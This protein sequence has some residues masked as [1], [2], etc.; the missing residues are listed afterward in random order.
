MWE[1]WLVA[2]MEPAWT[3]LETCSDHTVWA[4]LCY[5][6]C[7]GRIMDAFRFIPSHQ[8]LLHPIPVSYSRHVAGLLGNTE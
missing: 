5:I 1:A 8:T 4:L 6:S 3:P 7:V 2:P